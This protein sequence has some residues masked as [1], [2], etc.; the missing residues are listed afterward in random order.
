M[1]IERIQ[2]FIKNTFRI[3]RRIITRLIELPFV[4]SAFCIIPLLTRKAELRLARFVGR[5]ISGPLG[6]KK[7]KVALTNM[8][9]VY[10]DSK[11]PAEK[12]ELYRQQ[13]EHFAMIL[14]DYF[15]FSRKT[16]ERVAKFC[17]MEEPE[18]ERR[19]AGDSPG[20]FHTSHIGN[21]EIG[22]QYVALRGRLITSVFRP[23]GTKLT[24]QLLLRFRE[25]TG[26]TT[27]AREGA[28]VGILRT[29][30]DNGLVAVLLDQHTDL[31]DGGIYLD[32]FGLPAAFSNVIGQISNKH[33]VPISSVGII[34]NRDLDRYIV[35]S[36]GSISGEEA[37]NM[38]P[39]EITK[40]IVQNT[41]KMI[42]DAPGQWLW[43]YRRWK[44][45]RPSDD[46]SRFPYYAVLDTSAE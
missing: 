35:K 16:S 1:F 15:W 20:F 37:A 43:T 2:V 5:L 25:A 26:Q 11:T 36:Y 14:L 30:K 17:V 18:L 34:Y 28:V 24:M 7:K 31:V 41:E 10:G 6:K 45:F 3:I 19:I 13:C 42:L 23:L 12:E 21:W 29:F 46:K 9:I 40:W 32:F 22:G 33:S 27:V 44:R 8:D 39:E 38:K 4:L